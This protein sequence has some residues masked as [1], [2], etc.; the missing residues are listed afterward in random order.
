MTILKIVWICNFSNAEVQTKLPLWKN[1]NECGILISN[2]LK[3]YET[4]EG[5]ELHLISPHNYLK[6]QTIRLAHSI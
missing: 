6:K 5:I 3:D 2:L 4:R 1:A